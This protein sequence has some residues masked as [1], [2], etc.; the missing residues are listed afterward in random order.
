MTRGNVVARMIPFADGASVNITVRG[1]VTMRFA[2]LAMSVLP[3]LTL[4]TSGCASRDE[5]LPESAVTAL[6]RAFNSGDAA[7][8]A[9]VY[10]DDAEIIPEDG[11]VVRG[12]EAITA[13]FKDQVAREIS[14]GTETSFNTTRGDIGVEQGTYRI[15]DVQRGLDVEYGEYLNVWR[16]VNGQWRAFR[17]MYN[18]TMSQRTGISVAPEEE[19]PETSDSASPSAPHPATPGRH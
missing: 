4:V 10:S 19:A 17:S 18:V 12:H 7:A 2:L 6:E 8:C 13:F 16:K 5:Q 11:P 9:A 1:V 15:R 14:F 3:C